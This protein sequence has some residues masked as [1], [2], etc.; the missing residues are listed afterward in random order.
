MARYTSLPDPFVKQLEE[1]PG[2]VEFTTGYT[3]CPE[4]ERCE[5]SVVYLTP[6]EQVQAQAA[7]IRLYGKSSATR[8]N[9]QGC[10]CPFYG[11]PDRGCVHYQSR[12]L[13]CHLFP[14]D[15]VEHED[16]GSHWWVLFG[17]CEEVAKGKLRGRVEDARRIATEIDRRMPDELRQA[18]MADAGGALFE[19]MFYQH[20]IHYLLP[21]T[22]PPQPRSK[23]D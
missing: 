23:Y 10:R 5:R 16:D 11:G 17:A 14:I 15:I 8:M 1:I 12:P 19:P 21:L 20:P 2:F 3:Q 4:C 13:I 7:G 22:P 6:H 18:F 9:R